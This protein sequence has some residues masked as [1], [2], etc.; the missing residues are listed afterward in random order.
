ML[1]MAVTARELR[2]QL[3]ATKLDLKAE[4]QNYPTKADLDAA[5]Q[6]YPT[7]EDLK[8]YRDDLF[9]VRDELRTHFSVVAERFTDEFKSLHDWAE[10]N[11]NGLSARAATFAQGYGA[12]P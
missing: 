2:D 5:L 6:N 10:A 4:L 9:A 12:P 3:N 7:K 1:E 11:T 8:A